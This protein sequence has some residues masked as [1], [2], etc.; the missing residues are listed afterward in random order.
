MDVTRSDTKLIGEGRPVKHTVDQRSVTWIFGVR[1]PIS[2]IHF[3]RRSFKR[4]VPE[5]CRTITTRGTGVGWFGSGTN[6]SLNMTSD[7]SVNMTS[8][9]SVTMTSDKKYRVRDYTTLRYGDYQVEVLG[10]V[11]C[12]VCVNF[13]FYY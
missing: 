1:I 8:D 6:T 4:Y 5:F 7:T 12:G 13:A 9:T 10:C 2:R 3:G 11:C